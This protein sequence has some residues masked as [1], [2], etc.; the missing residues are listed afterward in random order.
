MKG[1][2]PP[3]LPPEFLYGYKVTSIG[4][5]CFFCS[6]SIDPLVDEN[7]I[8]IS[9]PTKTLFTTHYHCF[10]QMAW[11]MVYFITHYKPDDIVVN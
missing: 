3:E 11:S 6:N 2:P 4:V 7:H 8:E 5:E 1:T 10:H 9:I